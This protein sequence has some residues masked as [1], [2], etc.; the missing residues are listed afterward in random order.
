[1]SRIITEG[2]LN[3]MTGMSYDHSGA[4]HCPDYQTIV[5]LWGGGNA[6]IIK[7]PNNY[8]LN[9][10]VKEEDIQDPTNYI[11]VDIFNTEGTTNIRAT[12]TFTDIPQET[13]DSMTMNIWLTGGTMVQLGN[14]SWDEDGKYWNQ[15][16]WRSPE[17]LGVINI[18]TSTMS[19]QEDY[20]YKYAF[21]APEEK[22]CL[23]KFVLDG[24]ILLMAFNQPIKVAD[25]QYITT[26]AGDFD[27]GGEQG[28]YSLTTHEVTLPFDVNSIVVI[29]IPTMPGY[30]YVQGE[31][32]HKEVNINTTI[33]S[34]HAHYNGNITIEAGDS[35]HQAGTAGG[36]YSIGPRNIGQSIYVTYNASPSGH[37]WRMR[38]ESS[39][40][41]YTLTDGTKT[42]V[43]YADA[44]TTLTFISYT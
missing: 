23:F 39:G 24:N 17:E 2:K 7:Q 43:G 11:T 36:S 31:F 34:G 30:K 44:D 4:N 10:L 8:Q 41:T 29:D 1:M 22:E 19:V 5:E 15:Y 40:N 27:I 20:K 32:E 16:S 33:T 21:K 6:S 13:I 14:Y 9:Q 26:S 28:W 12:P 42:F 25:Y 3:E 18:N 37:S 38:N 35:K